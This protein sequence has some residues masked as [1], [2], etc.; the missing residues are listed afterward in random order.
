MTPRSD[1]A[2]EDTAARVALWRALHVEV[3]A[4]PHVLVDEVGLRLLAPP[5]DWRERGDMNPQFTRSFR[6]SIVARA[7]FVEDLVVEQAERGVTQYVILGAGLDSFAQRRPDVASRLQVFEI[8]RPGPQRWKQQ[9]LIELGYGVPPWLHFVPV[10]FEA[11]AS[12]RVEL[13]RAGF[14]AGKPAVVASTGVSMYLTREANAA[15]LREVA[16]LA[17]GSTFAMTFML[18]LDRVAPDLRADVQTAAKGARANRTPFISFF[19]PDEMLALARE[20]GFKEVEHVSAATLSRRYFANRT[21]GL[22][23]PQDAEEFLVART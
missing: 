1:L 2:P 17:P 19:M 4:P 8:D 16:T 14:D 5:P 23:P 13:A 11:G 9:R 21:D 15:T 18:P 22:R 10:D 12:W 3:D 6:A 20:A 7:R